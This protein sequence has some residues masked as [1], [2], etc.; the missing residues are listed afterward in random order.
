MLLKAFISSFPSMEMVLS[1]SRIIFL[2][3][4][5]ALDTQVRYL[6]M[7]DFPLISATSFTPRA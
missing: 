4:T 7:A 5:H 3:R 6:Y 1:I 2:Y